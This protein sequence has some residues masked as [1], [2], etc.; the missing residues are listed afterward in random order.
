MGALLI[1]VPMGQWP[2]PVGGS[3]EREE[4]DIANML[5]RKTG[6]LASRGGSSASCGGNAPAKEQRRG[7]AKTM[8]LG[9]KML[10]ESWLCLFSPERLHGSE[11]ATNVGRRLGSEVADDTW[12]QNRRRP[13][14]EWAQKR[15]GKQIGGRGCS[16]QNEWRWW[17]EEGK[18]QDGG[19]SRRAHK[20]LEEGA[21]SA[22]CGT[23]EG[24][25]VT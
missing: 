8:W 11:L 3:W 23:G 18:A 17:C 1:G 2:E 6:I 9:S 13:V 24:A 12:M 21:E 7:L 15:W 19:R 10:L 22:L 5:C 4:A 14:K 25:R 20:G 16:Y